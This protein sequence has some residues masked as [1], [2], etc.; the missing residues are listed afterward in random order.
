MPACKFGNRLLP[1][2]HISFPHWQRRRRLLF[3]SGQRHNLWSRPQN[4]INLASFI[5][6]FLI[7]CLLGIYERHLRPNHATLNFYTAGKDGLD[8]PK[9]HPWKASE[10]VRK[11]RNG[12]KTAFKRLKKQKSPVVAHLLLAN[13]GWMRRTYAWPGL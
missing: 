5:S 2:S 7:F 10:V 6:A 3:N 9:K 1:N 12:L 8:S 11:G 13:A 4:P